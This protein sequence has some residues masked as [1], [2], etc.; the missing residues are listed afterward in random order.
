MDTNRHLLERAEI[1]WS[2]GLPVPV[3][4]GTQMIAAG[5]D[6]TALEG[7]SL[8][9]GEDDDGYSCRS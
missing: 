8:D 5:L 4:L 1:Y 7:R 3:D 2:Q 9:L 6:V